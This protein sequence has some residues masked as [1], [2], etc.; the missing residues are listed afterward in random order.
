MIVDVHAHHT[1][2]DYLVR[3]KT[4]GGSYK[5]RFTG[6]PERVT[7]AERFAM[8]DEAGVAMQIL[9]PTN[10]P[11][12]DDVTEG[13]AACRQI[14]DAYAALHAEYPERLDLW[15]SLP[16]PHIAESLDELRRGLD[17]LGGRGIVIG[18]F[19]LGGSVAD[20]KFDP[21]YAELDRRGAVV[22][23]H[24]CQTGIDSPHVNEWGLTVCA[25]A[26]LEDSMVVLH[27]M[28]ARIPERFP[29]IRFIVPHFG[30]ILPMLLNRLDG[31]M[32][33][34][35]LAEKPSVTAR[36]FYYDT[37]GWGSRAALIA[38][39]EA[40]GASQIVT[41]SDFPVLLHHESY[42][43]TFDHIRGSD[44]PADQ[45]ETILGNAG[46]LVPLR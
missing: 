1:P 28:A 10:A 32:P 45:I 4:L 34:Q 16:L 14:N 38:A 27:L 11:Y 9:S 19:C 20:A 23:L 7:M 41:G 22:F 24:P 33:Q 46:K 15:I 2:A 40:F 39:V 18:C 42:C 43:Q 31:Q 37:V 25:G 30:G 36:R 13:V 5:D 26:S 3:S 29:N 44:L 35:D 6:Q 21:V 12:S 8:M 17:E